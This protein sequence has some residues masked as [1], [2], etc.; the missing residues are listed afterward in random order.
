[1]SAVPHTSREVQLRRRP[2]GLPSEEDFA[3]VETAVPDPGPGQMLVRNLWLSVDPYMRGRMTGRD[4]YVSG[5][6]VGQTLEGGALGRVEAS[7]GGRFEPG[8][9][10]LSMKGWREWFVSDGRDLSPVDVSAAP[11]QAHLGV[12][13]MPGLTAYVGLLLHGQPKAGETVFVTGGAGAVG[14][15]VCQLARLKGCRVVAT[16]G[17]PEKVQWLLHEARVDVALD[18]RALGDGPG[19]ER[20][21]WAAAP[22]GVD[23]CFDNVGGRHLE[24]GLSAMNDFG[25]V[26]LCGMISQYNDTAPAPGPR[27]LW[28]AIVRRLALRGFIVSDHADLTPRFVRDMGSWVRAGEIRWRE[29]VRDG[30]ESAPGAFIGL[31]RGENVG[32][33]LV[34]LAE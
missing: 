26:V 32:K 8:T 17:G 14:S 5:F 2:E 12:L 30:I 23:V 19:L 29:T 11:P 3:I 6:A 25:R 7:N 13:G 15:L 21:L 34:R 18:Y 31:F 1:M 24:A 10:V 22:R 27:N 20:A 33:M 9:H 4:T 16:A 28:I